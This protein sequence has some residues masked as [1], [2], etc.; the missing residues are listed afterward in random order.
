[1]HRAFDVLARHHHQVRH[2]VDDHHDVRHR[3][4]VEVFRLVDGFAGLA[5]EAGLHRARDL[6]ALLVRLCDTGVEAV[7][8]AHADLRHLAVTVFHLA[9]GPFQ[10]DD[11]LL[12][13]GDD[14]GQQMRDAV[15]D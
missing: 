14:R 10:R 15:I 2:L 8:V 11:G 7:D 13:I 9:H 6:L 4:Q 3:L 12:R 1:L 5:I